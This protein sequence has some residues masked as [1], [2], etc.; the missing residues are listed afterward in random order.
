MLRIASSLA[1]RLNPFT[2]SPHVEVQERATVAQGLLSSLG[3]TFTPVSTPEAERKK[4]EAAEAAMLALLEGDEAAAPA[5]AVQADPTTVASVLRALFEEPLKPV[6]ASAQKKVPVPEG[7][8]LDAW[9]NPPED[10]EPD[11]FLYASTW[12]SAWL[13]HSVSCPVVLIA[14]FCPLS[15]RRRS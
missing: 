6:K 3:I 10:V 7:L 13:A 15:Q 11:E 2:Q 9:I 8:N 5:P 12:A 14:A 4:K 1:T